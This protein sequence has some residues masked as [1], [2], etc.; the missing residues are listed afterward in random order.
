MQQPVHVEVW[1]AHGIAAGA[2]GAAAGLLHPY[3]PKGKASLA[4]SPCCAERCPNSPHGQVKAATAP[5]AVFADSTWGPMCQLT[6]TIR[7]LGLTLQLPA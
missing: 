6:A 7:P 2:S 5:L 4:F 1:D 3:T